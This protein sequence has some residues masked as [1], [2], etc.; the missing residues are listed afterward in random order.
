MLR[1]QINEVISRVFPGEVVGLDMEDDGNFQFQIIPDPKNRVIIQ[2]ENGQ[3][4]IIKS[5]L[6]ELEEIRSRDIF[7]K[8]LFINMDRSA[9]LALITM[10]L[11]NHKYLRA[12]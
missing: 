11:E 3:K 9:D 8:E 6:L 12:I 1:A 10:V 5:Q 2:V 7:K 4:V